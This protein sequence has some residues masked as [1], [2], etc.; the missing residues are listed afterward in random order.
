[1][2]SVRSVQQELH[3]FLNIKFIL[4]MFIL[5]FILRLNL[6]INEIDIKIIF[7]SVDKSIP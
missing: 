3:F 2:E 5:I 7:P 4:L 6:N 1:M